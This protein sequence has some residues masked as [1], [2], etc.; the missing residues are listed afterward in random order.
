MTSHASITINLNENN[1]QNNGNGVA[2]FSPIR[3]S[4]MAKVLEGYIGEIPEDVLAKIQWTF[5]NWR[6]SSGCIGE[7]TMDFCQLVKFQKMYWR[8]YN[9]LLPIG[10]IP[11]DVLAKVQWT[12][13]NWR[14]SRGC[15]GEST[16]NFRQLAKLQGMY[17][18]KYGGLSPT[19]ETPRD[20][21]AKVWWTFTNDESSVGESLIDE[22]P[23][24][25][26]TS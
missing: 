19:G 14:N 6:N 12:F 2:G 9:G 23:E 7:S 25:L 11:E 13:A 16:V 21:L 17:W 8:K 4:P 22:I 24:P 18:R 3:R 15:I 5:A 20:V 26:E 1:H 10:E